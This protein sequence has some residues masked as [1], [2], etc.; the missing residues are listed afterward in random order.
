M[1]A[2]LFLYIYVCIERYLDII[3]FFCKYLC[4]YVCM[5]VCM[6]RLCVRLYVSA[7]STLRFDH[8]DF[9]FRL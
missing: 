1:K 3:M 9:M 6:F 5:Y 8:L 7:D 4:I 2:C